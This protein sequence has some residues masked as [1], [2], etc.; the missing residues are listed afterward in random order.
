[1]K[2]LLDYVFPI[3]VSQPIPAASTAFLKQVGVV[4]KP[5]SG[6]EDKVGSITLC[7]N[8]AEVK[9]LTDNEDIQHLFDAGMT[10]VYVLLADNL[11]LVEALENKSDFFTLLVSSDFGDAD[12]EETVITPE[13]KSSAVI[14]N[15]TYTSKLE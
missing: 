2:I 15:I 9:D 6:Q 5:K 14:G 12:L 10:R 8:M 4:A 3:T 1:M 13:A 7:T 11:N